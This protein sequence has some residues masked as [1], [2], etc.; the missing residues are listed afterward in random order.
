M[1]RALAGGTAAVLGATAALALTSSVPAAAE[2]EFIVGSG[3]ADARILRVGPAAGQLALA[4]TIGLSLADYLGTLGRGEARVADF[5][6]LDGSAEDIKAHMPESRTESTEENSAA[7]KQ[8]TFLGTPTG[9]PVTLGVMEQRSSAAT[10]PR[11]SSLVTLGAVGIPGVVEIGQATAESTSGVVEKKTREAR[12]VTRIG[13]IKLGG[14]VVTLAGLTWEAVQRTG[15]GAGVSGS[16]RIEGLTIAGQNVTVPSNG[17]EL[18]AVLPQINA[19]L[20]PTGL[21][22]DP[23]VVSKDG[24]L[25]RVSPLGIRVVNSQVGQTAVAPVVGALQP[26]REPVT[27]GVI[28]NCADCTVAILLADVLAGVVTGGGRFDLEI[29]GVTGYT[30]GTR[31][32]SPFNFDF[33]GLGSGATNDF[34]GGFDSGA[35]GFGDTSAAPTSFDAGSPSLGSAPSR[36]AGFTAPAPGVAAGSGTTQAGTLAST[37]RKPTGST[38]GAAALIGLAG[39][40]GAIA[41]GGADFRAIRAA[42]RTIPN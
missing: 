28:E 12:G 20:A 17:T 33:S 15:A 25:A 4:P 2:E 6:A 39:L 37:N 26:A 42:R 34:A 35:A 24:D 29:G 11:G 1:I 3:R 8:Q 18:A 14:G 21:V 7:G 38:G 10:D 5:A 22:L 23:P 41:L 40:L 9:T 16:F 30:E 19:A 27:Q 31:Y 32:D 36:A 13:S